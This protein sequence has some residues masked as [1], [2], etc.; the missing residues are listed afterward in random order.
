MWKK[1]LAF[2]ALFLTVFTISAF[3]SGMGGG[4]YEASVVALKGAGG[5]NGEAVFRTVGGFMPFEYTLSVTV[6]GLEPNT[7][8]S[9]WLADSPAKEGREPLGVTTNRFKT[10]GSGKGRYVTSVSHQ[11]LRPWRSLAVYRQSGEAG[12]KAPALKGGIRFY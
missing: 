10:D 2:A 3:A 8:Y 7:E 5:A 4:D 1:A 12:E 11:K 9:V 6:W